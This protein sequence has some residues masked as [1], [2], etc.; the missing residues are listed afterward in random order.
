R[1]NSSTITLRCMVCF[2]VIAKRFHLVNIRCNLYRIIE[3]SSVTDKKKTQKSVQAMF[4]V[5]PLP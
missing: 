5:V 4:P 3:K 1:L 2:S